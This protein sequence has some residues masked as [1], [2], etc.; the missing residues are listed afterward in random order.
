MNRIIAIDGTCAS[1]KGLLSKNLSGKLGLPHLNT[2]ALY[3]NIALFL[4]KNG[5][6]CENRETVIAN[7]GRISFDDLENLELFGENVGN[8]ASKI[9]AIPE[10]RDFLYKFQKDFSSNKSGAILDGR[11]IGTVICPEAGHKFFV[12]AA[13]E[14]RAERRYREMIKNGL[15]TSYDEVLEKIKQRDQSDYERKT[16]PLKKAKD[17]IEIDTTRMTPGEVLNFALEHINLQ[18]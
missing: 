16:A 11:D 5:F 10:V 7:L 12:N 17:A 18:K 1:G 14:I 2:G 4:Y 9:S 3:R 15:K 13:V 6:D 8:I